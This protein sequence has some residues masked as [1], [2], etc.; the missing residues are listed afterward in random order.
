MKKIHPLLLLFFV[1]AGPSYSQAPELWG[2]MSIG[3][4]FGI[5]GIVRI[6]GDGSGYVIDHACTGGSNGGSMNC[7]LVPQSPVLLFGTSTSGGNQAK[8]DV[9]SYNPFTKNY[10]M[11]FSMDSLSGYY[12]RGPVAITPAGK[13]YGLTN[14]GGLFNGGVLFEYDIVNGQ[15]TKLHD[16]DNTTGQLPFGGVIWSGGMNKIYGMTTSG[17]QNAGGVIFSYDITAASF[18]VVH[19]FDF[20]TGFFGYGTLRAGSNG[21]L[22]GMTFGG[23]NLGYGVIFSFNPANNNYTVIHHFDGTNGSV[24]MGQLME[25]GGTLYGCT[26]QGGTQNKGVIFSFSIAGNTLTKLHDFDGTGGASPYGGVIR[27]SDG[28]LYGMTLNGGVNNLGAIYSFNLSNNLYTKIYDGSF[29][30]GG[31]PGADL[32]EYSGPTALAEPVSV[33][34]TLLLFPNPSTGNIT[35]RHSGFEKEFIVQIVDVLGN[36]VCEVPVTT[37]TSNLTLNVKPGIYFYFSSEDANRHCGKLIIE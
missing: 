35:I 14:N 33:Q 24:P 7:T 23:G 16:F 32:V 19:H 8:G 3:G 26:S 28:K 29:A 21:L 22:Y 13:V 4:S 36:K 34:P 37:A 15:Y 27:A 25:D 1:I 31:L 2:T 6:M 17:G 10:S 11:L 30:T 5:G 20:S 12:P 9:F 18:S